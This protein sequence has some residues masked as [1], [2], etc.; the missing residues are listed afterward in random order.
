MKRLKRYAVLLM[1][2]LLICVHAMP[3]T[4]FERH[5]HDKYMSEVLFK[6]FK[7]PEN[8][9][10]SSEKLELL[11]CASYLT[12][13]QFNSN[14]QK[15]LDVLRS[16]GVKNIPKDVMDISFNASGKTHRN[17]THRGW[18][19]SYGGVMVD[20]WPLRQAI[21]LNTADAIFEFDGDEAKKE[22]FCELIYYVHILGD[23]MDDESYKIENGLKI[24]AGGRID[25]NDI[26]HKL[27]DCF[28][29]LFKDQKHTHK[30]Q[31][32]TNALNRLNSKLTKLVRSEGGIN[33]DDKFELR[34]MYV[35]DLMKVLTLYI[36]EMLKDEP[37]FNKAFYTQ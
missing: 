26:I 23:Y 15:D 35:E 6:N 29:V 32:L 36:P 8:D 4:A 1:A 18:D 27:L 11:E 31:S 7:V 34:Q 16:Y 28:E 22:S 17:Y 20:K 3:V 10:V 25:R 33:T 5:E 30:Y 24:D 13:D 12:I 9:P 21:L 14:G 19:Y 2:I 37:F